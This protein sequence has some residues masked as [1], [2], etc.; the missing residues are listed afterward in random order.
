MSFFWDVPSSPAGDFRFVPPDF[1]PPGPGFGMG[2]ANAGVVLLARDRVIIGDAGNGLRDR[3]R[4]GRGAAS[5]I[6]MSRCVSAGAAMLSC[7]PCGV[8]AMMLT[9]GA[10]AGVGAGRTDGCVSGGG[11]GG[12]ICA[13]TTSSTVPAGGSLR[14]G[15][16]GGLNVAGDTKDGGMIGAGDGRV[17]RGGTGGGISVGIGREDIGGTG[18]MAT[19]VGGAEVGGTGGLVVVVGSVVLSATSWTLAGGEAT[20]VRSMTCSSSVAGGMSSCFC[21]SSSTSM[22]LWSVPSRRRMYLA[23]LNTFHTPWSSIRRPS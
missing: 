2:R 8:A 22:S 23:S 5:S 14:A 20:S 12:L 16:G 7:E 21:S 1:F 11:G 10:S 3:D 9:V 15:A 17:E 13:V 6:G 19:R 18:G 4:A